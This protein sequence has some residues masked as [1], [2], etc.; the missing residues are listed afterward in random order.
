M[1]ANKKKN[2]N[3]KVIAFFSGVSLPSTK[4]NALVN[5]WKKLSHTNLVHLREMI[6]T[7]DFGDNC[8]FILVFFKAREK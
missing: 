6:V 2:A 8:N 1:Q 3:N 4:C 7:R 5:N